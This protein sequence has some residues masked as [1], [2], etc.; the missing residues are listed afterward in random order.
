MNYSATIDI[1]GITA[2]SYANILS[3]A[4][5]DYLQISPGAH[6]DNDTQEG[7]KLAIWAQSV[8]DSNNALIAIYNG[9]SPNGSSGA[10]LS[11]LVK[12]NGLVRQTPSNS[13]CAV[14][15]IG[16]TG[17]IINLTDLT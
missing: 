3:Q 9:F 5:A 8:V 17:T 15:V 12:I 14:N 6:L 16:V 7:Q 1:N 10:W 13:T 11:N 4:K 2:P